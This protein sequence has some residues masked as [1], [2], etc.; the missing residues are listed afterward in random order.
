MV[1][2]I[3]ETIENQKFLKKNDFFFDLNYFIKNLRA[4]TN[5][6]LGLDEQ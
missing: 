5:T 6:F 4:Y 3:Y 2:G 1:F